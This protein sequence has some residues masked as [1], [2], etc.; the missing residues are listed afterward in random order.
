AVEGHTDWA[1]A[2][3]FSPGGKLLASA[4]SDK[5]LDSG[6]QAQERHYRSLTGIHAGSAPWPSR[7]IASY[8]YPLQTT[9]PLGS[10]TQPR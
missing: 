4:S 1:K 3:A 7:Q 5:P 9:I 10:G 8:W 6:T 2:V